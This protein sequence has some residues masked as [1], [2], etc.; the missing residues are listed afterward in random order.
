MSKHTIKTKFEIEDLVTIKGMTRE[1]GS[2]SKS[3]IPCKGLITGYLVDFC[4]GGVQIHYNIR[5]LARINADGLFGQWAVVDKT[6]RHLEQELVLW[7][8]PTDG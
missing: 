6:S 2:M 5:W 3:L 4:P 7:K 1:I 8:E